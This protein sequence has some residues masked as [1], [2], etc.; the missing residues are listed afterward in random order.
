MK[1]DGIHLTLLRGLGAI[2]MYKFLVVLSTLIFQSED[3]SVNAEQTRDNF[4]SR[5][6]VCFCLF[7]FFKYCYSCFKIHILYSVPLVYNTLGYK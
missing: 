4:L 1:I 7:F 6:V 5:I 2:F 3:P